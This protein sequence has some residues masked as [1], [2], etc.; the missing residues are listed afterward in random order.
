M[1]R[2]KFFSFLGLGAVGAC[3]GSALMPQSDKLAEA[4]QMAHDAGLFASYPG[5]FTHTV[6]HP[7]YTHS[8]YWMGGDGLYRIASN[9]TAE[10]IS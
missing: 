8:V 6:I 9:G 4:R 2:R 3:A 1:D 10:R 7:D 5:G